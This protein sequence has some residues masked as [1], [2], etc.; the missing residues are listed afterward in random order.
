VVEQVDNTP[1]EQRQAPVGVLTTEH[2]DTWGA[3]REQMEKDGTN[4][5]SFKSLDDSLF[6]FCLDDYSSPSDIDQTHR[7]IFHARNGHN[8]W[9]DKAL[10]FIVENNGRAGINGEVGKDRCVID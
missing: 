9:F 3:L 6:V 1:A 4:A 10:S 7:N 5:A 8:R 2:R